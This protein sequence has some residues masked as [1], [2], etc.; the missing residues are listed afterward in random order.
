MTKNIQCR[1]S[2][3]KEPHV[4]RADDNEADDNAA[5]DFHNNMDNLDPPVDEEDGVVHRRDDVEDPM[6]MDEHDTNNDKDE[7]GGNQEQRANH[8]D[9][10]QRANHEDQEQRANPE[11]QEQRANPEDQEQ[12]AHHEDLLGRSDRSDIQTRLAERDQFDVSD[13]LNP[14]QW[15]M[16]NWT[17]Y[18]FMQ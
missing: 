12:R 7:E 18:F 8:E 16:N 4:D 17:Q 10:E 15:H 6:A 13:Q 1:K 9:Q 14:Y 11:D 5:V 2:R 3:S